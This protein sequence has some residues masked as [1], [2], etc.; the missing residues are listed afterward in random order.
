M[1]QER[2]DW[3]AIEKEYK[4]GQL[5]VRA[6]ARKYGISATAV[7]KKAKKRGWVRDKTAEVRAKTRVALMMADGS[8]PNGVQPGDKEV[9]IAVQT[10]LRV[11]LEHRKH[12]QSLRNILAKLL[13]TAEKEASGSKSRV[14]LEAMSRTIKNLVTAEKEIIMLERQAFGI[15]ASPAEELGATVQHF[16]EAVRNKEGKVWQL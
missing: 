5:S 10:N 15:D 16:L 14:K 1:S 7:Q 2:A 3:E 9:E 12:I 13:K 11:I 8:G 6:I 4:L